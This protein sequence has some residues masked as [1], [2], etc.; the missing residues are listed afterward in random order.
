MPHVILTKL[1]Q[2]VCL[3]LCIIHCEIHETRELLM[4]TKRASNIKGPP[5]SRYVL[6]ISRIIHSLKGV[7]APWPH[8]ESI[9]GVS[10]MIDDDAML[11]LTPHRIPSSSHPS[12]HSYDNSTATYIYTQLHVIRIRVIRICVILI[13]SA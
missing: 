12:I 10:V 9:L 2:G 4:R 8:C 13:R 6:A 11:S 7:R 1:G 3:P 5:L